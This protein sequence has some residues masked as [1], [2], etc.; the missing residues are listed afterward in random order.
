MKKKPTPP[1]DYT[2]ELRERREALGLKRFEV[3]VNDA[4]RDAVRRL[5]ERLKKKREAGK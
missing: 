4:D 1:R 2:A 3:Y 5:V